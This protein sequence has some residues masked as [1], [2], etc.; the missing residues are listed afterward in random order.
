MLKFAAFARVAPIIDEWVK[1][2]PSGRETLAAYRR[3]IASQRA[4]R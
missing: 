2:T 4:T 1:A 3:E